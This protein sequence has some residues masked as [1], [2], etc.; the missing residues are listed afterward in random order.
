VIGAS[1]EAECYGIPRAGTGSLEFWRL[2]KAD[3]LLQF[4]PGAS[5]QPARAPTNSR[6]I[7]WTAN[8]PKG[9]PRLGLGAVQ[10]VRS[11]R[12]R[13]YGIGWVTRFGFSSAERSSSLS[14]RQSTQTRLARTST[15]IT[16]RF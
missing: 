6:A 2:E 12:T 5:P 1:A 15:M 10:V 3:E 9:A 13:A 16:D 14:S 11:Q 7:P 4:P 8:A